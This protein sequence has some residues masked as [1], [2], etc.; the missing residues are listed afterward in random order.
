MH[1]MYACLKGN[2]RATRTGL[3]ES[4]RGVCEC[5]GYVLCMALCG[6]LCWLSVRCIKDGMTRVDGYDSL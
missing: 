2:R 6:S 5:V 3:Y 1:S 4:V